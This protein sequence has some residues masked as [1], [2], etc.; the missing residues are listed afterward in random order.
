M[1][2]LGCHIEIHPPHEDTTDYFN[3]K[4]WH[5]V[6]LLALVDARCRFI[7]VNSGSPGRCNDSQIFQTSSLKQQLDQCELLTELKRS[8]AG[9]DIPV[10]IIGDSAFRLSDK[11][12]KPYPYNVSQSQEQKQFNYHLSK[13]RRV[14]ENAFGHLKARFRRIGKGI[15]NAI[16][17][18]NAM[19]LSCCVLHSFLSENNDTLNKNWLRA[20]EIVEANRSYPDQIVLLEDETNNPGVKR[21]A[22]SSYL[23]EFI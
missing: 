1:N 14:V 4:G 10:F 8:I 11:L 12:M 13:S 19:I 23:R 22:I 9:V 7:Y 6:V 15:D 20:L 2:R 18:A 21:R 16:K 5:S 3:Y 17:N